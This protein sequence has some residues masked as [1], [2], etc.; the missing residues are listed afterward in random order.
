MCPP[1]PSP[2]QNRVLPTGEIVADP[3]RGMFTGNRGNLTFTDGKLGVSRW[4]HQHWIICDLKHPKGRYHGPMPAR[5]WTPLFFLDEAVGLAAGHRPCAY[6]RPKSYQTFKAAWA[7][8]HGAMGHLAM[9]RMLHQA[10]VTRRRHQIRH[11]A[12]C[13]TLPDGVLVLIAGQP[14]VLIGDMAHPYRPDGYGAAVPRPTRLTDVLTP[15][16]TVA[17]LRAGFRPKLHHTA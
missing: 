12:D 9:D 1:R 3:A 14:Y 5:A 2:L 8:A 10:R 7:T 17:A 11:Q 16:P 13:T 6:C 4:K 15:A